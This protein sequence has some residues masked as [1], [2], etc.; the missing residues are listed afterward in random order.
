M[1][2]RRRAPMAVEVIHTCMHY[3][4][5][6]N[7]SLLYKERYYLWTEG[8]EHHTARPARQAGVVKFTNERVGVYPALVLAPSSCSH[9]FPRPALALVL[10]LVHVL[11]PVPVPLPFCPSPPRIAPT[12]PLPPLGAA[13]THP[14]D[15]FHP[16]RPADQCKPAW[17][18]PR[19]GRQWL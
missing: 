14:S 7:G 12:S 3:E 18:S 6:T 17:K 9:P 10:D 11:A 15:I 1:A 13:S 2:V 8:C 16:A 5:A 19:A 4:Q